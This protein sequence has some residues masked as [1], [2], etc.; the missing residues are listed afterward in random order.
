M[1]YFP[2]LQQKL[3]T[4]DGSQPSAGARY[5]VITWWSFGEVTL[6]MYG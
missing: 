3:R 2:R 4:W 5:V 6:K 1:Y